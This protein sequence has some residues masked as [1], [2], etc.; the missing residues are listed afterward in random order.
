MSIFII[1]PLINIYWFFIILS[2]FV[3]FDI[4][5][6]STQ[7]NQITVARKIYGI[8]IVIHD[9]LLYNSSLGEIPVDLKNSKT[10]IN[11]KVSKEYSIDFSL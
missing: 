6:G 9:T 8:R 3:N 7:F 5:I 2:R 1:V 4:Q 10:Y 11:C